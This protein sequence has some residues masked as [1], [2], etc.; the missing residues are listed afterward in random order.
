[1]RGFQQYAERINAC[2]VRPQRGSGGMTPWI[3]WNFRPS[4]IVSGNIGE[5]ST[6][7]ANISPCTQGVHACNCSAVIKRDVDYCDREC[8]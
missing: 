5:N 6:N 1:M 2:V 8:G 3:F 4:E 7:Y